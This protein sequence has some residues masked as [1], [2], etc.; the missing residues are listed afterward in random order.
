M[1]TPSKSPLTLSTLQSPTPPAKSVTPEPASLLTGKVAKS[2]PAPLV[3]A[4]L[5]GSSAVNT[6]L[7]PTIAQLRATQAAMSKSLPPVGK[8]TIKQLTSSQGLASA[9]TTNVTS[10]VLTVTSV[11]LNVTSSLA[12]Q[13]LY[14]PG[15]SQ[16]TLSAGK[17]QKTGCTPVTTATTFS[18]VTTMN[19]SQAQAN[20]IKPPSVPTISMLPSQ[21]LLKQQQQQQTASQSVLKQNAALVAAV[22]QT[23]AANASAATLGKST[24][25]VP[26][27]TFTMTARQTPPPNMV[28]SKSQTAVPSLK[29]TTGLKQT[30][31]MLSQEGIASLSSAGNQSGSKFV[32]LTSMAGMTGAE[33]TLMAQI[34]Q[35]AA[36]VHSGSPRAAPRAIR[37]PG[38][39]LTHFYPSQFYTNLLSSGSYFNHFWFSS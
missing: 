19:A 21:Q 22:G 36:A 33:S 23:V 16:S 28:V 15:L 25:T 24:P 39:S 3:Q 17:I 35:Q 29:P 37:L 38:K 32:A 34:M 10:S 12:A 1:A 13:L 6:S 8:Q 30:S 11:G 9:V 5:T 27:Q 26:K 14:S 18:L 2:N 4:S 31:L 7:S 20:Q